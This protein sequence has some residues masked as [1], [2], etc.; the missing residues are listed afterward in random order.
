MRL[1]LPPRMPRKMLPGRHHSRAMRD[2]A[3][4]P[5]YRRQLQLDEIVIYGIAGTVTL[6]AV[7][8]FVVQVVKHH[9]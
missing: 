9:G 5:R 3:N 7:A 1:G 6:L 8:V 4:T 2:F